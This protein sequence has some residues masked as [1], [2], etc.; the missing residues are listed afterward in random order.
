MKRKRHK[1]QGNNLQKKIIA[2]LAAALFSWFSSAVFLAEK[3][4][5]LISSGFAGL[6]LAYALYRVFL[7]RTEQ[8]KLEESEQLLAF[9]SGQ[10]ASGYTLER[11]LLDAPLALQEQLGSRSRLVH[12]LHRMKNKLEAQI[13]LSAALDQFSQAYACQRLSRDLAILPWLRLQGGQIDVY[14]RESHRQLHLE[15]AMQ[16]EVAAENSQ[17]MSESL[18]M[19][20]LPFIFGLLLFKQN[21]SLQ[22]LTWLKWAGL[23]FHFLALQVLSLTLIIA[24]KA[25]QPAAKLQPDKEKPK[26]MQAKKRKVF[27]SLYLKIMPSFYI[28]KINRLV[29]QTELAG[30]QEG[31]WQIYLAKKF[32]YFLTGLFISLLYLVSKLSNLWLALIFP[33]ALPLLQDL[34]L[35][36]RERQQR[37]IF[38]LTYPPLLNILALLMESG[39]TLQIALEL[40]SKGL[41]GFYSAEIVKQDLQQTINS[42]E[43]G[44]AAGQAVKELAEKCPLP[45][46]SSALRLAA[47]YDQQGSAELLALL[48]L[49]AAASWQ[50]YRN[51]LRRQLEQ[52]A[53][54]LFIPMGLALLNVLAIA[55]MPALASFQ[56]F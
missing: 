45:E 31:L 52:R 23:I 50:I 41:A 18:I 25:P 46:I 4:L 43:A 47:R 5:R 44:I 16:A 22:H 29:R 56:S 42:I 51:G 35:I 20:F 1:A 9:L 7:T 26:R 2:L 27:A 11:A 13:E 30:R 21:I 19:S 15:M 53:M 3:E 10:I 55:V 54:L 14:L 6:L 38:R 24:A 37:Q 36:S 48:S 12:L 39:L 33:L 49:Q 32:Y 17:R 40:A 28:Y 34:A 8:Q